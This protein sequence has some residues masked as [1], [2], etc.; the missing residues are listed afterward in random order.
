MNKKEEIKLTEGS[1]Y[2][3]ISIGGRDSTL[4]TEGIFSGYATIGL[5]EG[6]LLIQLGHSHG[7]LEGKYRIIPLH[8]ILAIDVLD[9]K[10]CESNDDTK[11]TNHYYS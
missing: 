9:V 10:V 8:A 4:E 11:E 6:G 1:R 3:I 5:E 7:H 2:K